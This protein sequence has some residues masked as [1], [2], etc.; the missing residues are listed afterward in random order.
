MDKVVP[1]LVRNYKF[2]LFKKTITHREA[3]LY[4]LSV[5]CSQD[6]MSRKDL[7]FTYENSPNFKV[8]QSL[9]SQFSVLELDSIKKCPGLPDYN[10]MA[11]LHGEQMIEFVKPL[12]VG[13]K[14]RTN[15]S[16]IDIADKKSGALITIE[17]STYDDDDNNLIVRNYAKLFIRGIGGF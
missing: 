5:G 14:L 16:I 15:N 2:G 8:V 1:S 17:S 11:L 13:A 6:P 12:K 10:P 4:A 3:I 7:K 9:V